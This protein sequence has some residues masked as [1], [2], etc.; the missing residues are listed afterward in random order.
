MVQRMDEQGST[1]AAAEQSTDQDASPDLPRPLAVVEMAAD[2]RAAF[3]TALADEHGELPE[4]ITRL[5]ATDLA[6]GL[7][8]AD[9]LALAEAT[10][11]VRRREVA[12]ATAVEEGAAAAVR[13]ARDVAEAAEAEHRTTM[14]QVRATADALDSLRGQ[15]DLLGGQLDA[16]APAVEATE[17]RAGLLEALA[18][19]AARPREDLRHR[20]AVAILTV[21]AEIEAER[22]ARAKSDPDEDPAVLGARARLDE[23]SAELTEFES[24]FGPASLDDA[25]RAAIES[26]HDEVE[27]LRGRRRAEAALA[28][29]EAAEAALLARHGYAS[30]LDYTIGNAT[31]EFGSLAAGGIDAARRAQR[32]A[33]DQLDAARRAV[34]AQLEQLEARRA[35]LDTLAERLLGAVSDEEVRALLAA[36]PAV[37]GDPAAWADYA[38]RSAAAVRHR[39]ASTGH[40]RALRDEL[41]AVEAGIRDLEAFAL[42]ARGAVAGTEVHLVALW[43]DVDREQQTLATA[44]AVR[45]AA[46][47]ALADAAAALDRRR[48]GEI[49]EVDDLLETVMSHVRGGPTGSVLLD[50]ALADLATPTAAALLQALVLRRPDGDVLC[51]TEDPELL[52]WAADHGVRGA[53]EPW[54]RTDQ[55]AGADA[56]NG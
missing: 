49:D 51:L 10:T 23:A 21:E 48:A 41:G 32:R 19:A 44:E 39:D 7:S 4:D 36:L 37:T 52:G 20:V 12:A 17:R 5:T 46:E 40:C 27:R 2:D 3:V 35:E 24:T 28:S 45:S 1:G 13:A 38:R 25:A 31:L 34:V 42:A 29:A 47:S 53:I 54:W 30:F 56:V 14:Q 26:A 16:V 55:P 43:S 6:T 33:A 50:C 18:D 8:A 9:L 11:D 22:A 15:R